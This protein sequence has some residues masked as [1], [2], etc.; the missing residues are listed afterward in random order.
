MP[1]GCTI[2]VSFLATSTVICC[3]QSPFCHDVIIYSLRM[4]SRCATFAEVVV[5]GKKVSS[6]TRRVSCR[7]RTSFH[8]KFSARS[9]NF[10]PRRRDTFENKTNKIASQVFFNLFRLW[11]RNALLSPMM[12]GI[13]IVI[14]HSYK[15]DFRS[16]VRLSSIQKLISRTSELLKY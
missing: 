11:Q 10:P 13:I 12:K 5:F 6:L 14:Y 7:R 4:L 9:L 15:N 16:D 3:L 8:S 1:R 2:G